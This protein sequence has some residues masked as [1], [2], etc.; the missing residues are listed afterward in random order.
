MSIKEVIN[1]TVC[2]DGNTVSYRTWDAS[3]MQM[4]IEFY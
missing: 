2:G 4:L 1:L 3:H